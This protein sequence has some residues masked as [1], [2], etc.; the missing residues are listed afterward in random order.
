MKVC[1]ACGQRFEADDWCCPG[2]GHFPEVCNGHLSFAPDLAETSD[3]FD[4]DYF[5]PLARLE[6]GHFWFRARNRLLIWALRTYFPHASSLLEIGCGT[7]FVLSGI[8]GAFSELRLSGSEI[9]SEGL[10]LAQKRLPCV[11]LFQMDARHV[12]FEEE[13]DVIGAFDVLEHIEED[14][15]V[16]H[17]MYQ[18]AKPG[19]G[20][21]L[22]VPQHRF[23]W[24]VVDQC[25]F[26][27]R[28]YARRELVEKV[29]Q[30]GFEIIRATGFVF[31]L[32]P[33]MLLSRVSRRRD[34]D[35]FDPVAELEVGHLLNAA[36]ERALGAERILIERGLSFPAGG[37]ILAVARRPWR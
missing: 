34:H 25:S 31:F 19:G 4:V 26:H 6:A 33:L 14:D 32:L 12:P 36:L 9:F 30:A 15:A 8:Q 13:F 23:L 16:L 27:K 10:I 35:D 2:C 18:A 24:T 22:T 11:T 17:Q 37:S 1:L 29:E 7:G 5:T 20:I 3:G 21:M 28:R